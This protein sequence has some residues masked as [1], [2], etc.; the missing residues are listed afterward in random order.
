M[1]VLMQPSLMYIEQDDGERSEKNVLLMADQIEV[2]AE[3]ENKPNLFLGLVAWRQL[4]F[5][6]LSIPSR[7][8]MDTETFSNTRTIAPN[9]GAESLGCKN[10]S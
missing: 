3:L 8:Q 1:A 10:V 2:K 5:N 7:L 4:G 6:A 9:V